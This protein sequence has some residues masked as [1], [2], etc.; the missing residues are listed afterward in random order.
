MTLNKKQQ[1][2][3]DIIY[4]ATRYFLR[5]GYNGATT[6]LIQK[7][8]GVSKATLYNHFPTKES[9][10]ASVVT[11]QCNHF[12][13]E[14]KAIGLPEENFH[15]ALQR[16][17][18]AYLT[19]LLAA[20]NLALFRVVVAEATRFPFLA[21]TFYDAGPQSVKDVIAQTIQRAMTQHEIAP[22]NHDPY[23]LAND[24][25]TVLRGQSQMYCLLHP[26]YVPDK[27]AITDWVNQAVNILLHQVSA[28]R[29]A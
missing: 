1:K 16:I 5:F 10:F 19:L 13:K 3:Q 17:G 24:F 8:A 6:D 4:A 22:D 2:T 23:L 14:V 25:I 9:L 15:A 29:S 7:E 21:K 12:I 18:V 20:D 28:G 26:D 11:S 27:D